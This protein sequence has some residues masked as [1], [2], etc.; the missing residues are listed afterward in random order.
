M[1]LFLS[2][3]LGFAVLYFLGR[4]ALSWTMAKDSPEIALSIDGKGSRVLSLMNRKAL[5]TISE[6]A[7]QKDLAARAKK[8]LKR[9]PLSDAAIL[10]HGFIEF[11]NQNFEQALWG[12][13]I[14]LSAKRKR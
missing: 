11:E 3:L 2:V 5:E 6:E 10:H 1:K 14:L 4:P 8:I 9:A 7:V 13:T 12:S